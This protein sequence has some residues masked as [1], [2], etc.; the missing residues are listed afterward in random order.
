[1]DIQDLFKAFSEVPRPENV[2]GD[3][4]EIDASKEDILYLV[5]TDTSDLTTDDFM[6][7]VGHVGHGTTGGIENDSITFEICRQYVDDYT[8]V[9]EDEIR[10]ALRLMLE[11]HHMLVEGAA[12]LAVASLMREKDRYKGKNVVFLHCVTEYPCPLNHVYMEKMIRMRENGLRVGYSDHTL[13]TEAGKYA[14]CLGAEYVEKHFTLNRYLPGR[15]Q[16]MSA[17]IEEMA[18]LAAWAKI[19]EDMRGPEISG[20]TDPEKSYRENYIGKWGDNS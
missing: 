9:T 18:E 11:K 17:T 20:L 16:K 3:R 1:M 7:Y 14:I 10:A 8:L 4:L 5:N 2:R 13:G 15:D 19:V 6:G 12:V